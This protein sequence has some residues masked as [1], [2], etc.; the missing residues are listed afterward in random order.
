MNP[1]GHK[2]DAFERDLQRVT[3]AYRKTR[4]EEPPALLDQAILNRARRAA[5][6]RTTR[7]WGFGWIHA[8]T[9]A[10]VI[11]LA[12]GIVLHVPERRSALPEPQTVPPQAGFRS[13]QASGDESV[14]ARE[15]AAPIAESARTGH[16]R[17]AQEKE[18]VGRES[19]GLDARPPSAPP[20]GGATAPGVAVSD[21]LAP[22]GPPEAGE[23]RAARIL[24]TSA[25]LKDEEPA[26]ETD[27]ETVGDLSGRPGLAGP[28]EPEFAAPPAGDADAA[29]PGSP[30][31]WLERIRGLLAAGDFE[32]FQSELAAFRSA[33]P[34]Y[35]LPEDIETALRGNDG[36]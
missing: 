21:D 19:A 17:Q 6:N 27:E 18:L 28:G 30:E 14:A 25:A 29:A 22:S 4:P 20:E 9:T 8:V 26:E 33:W 7:P 24:A 15:D 32:T 5:E 35:E 3:D 2:D 12:V 31:A 1:G 34:E 10:A 11:V 13:S 23:V 36:E 16:A